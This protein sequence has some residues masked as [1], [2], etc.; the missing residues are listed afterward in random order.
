[1]YNQ[2]NAITCLKCNTKLI[3]FLEK[4][5]LIYLENLNMFTTMQHPWSHFNSIL[6][7]SW[8]FG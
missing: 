8:L 4:V 3:L 2:L 5:A 1:M 6:K 7:K